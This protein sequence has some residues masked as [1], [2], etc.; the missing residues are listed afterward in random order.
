MKIEL[1]FGTCITES[2]VRVAE[3]VAFCI[4]F[5][6]GVAITRIAKKFHTLISYFHELLKAAHLS[7]IQLQLQSGK[8]KYHAHFFLATTVSPSV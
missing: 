7:I 5:V 3:V 1:Q 8:K 6:L 2:E 4:A